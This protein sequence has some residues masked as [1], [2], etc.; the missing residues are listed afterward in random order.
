MVSIRPA[1]PSRRHRPPERELRV[2]LLC[3]NNRPSPRQ[4]SITCSCDTVTLYL[5]TPAY[6]VSIRLIK[7]MSHLS[8]AELQP[9]TV[10]LLIANFWT[11]NWSWSYFATARNL[12]N[13]CK[14]DNV[15]PATS[16]ARTHA[17][18]H[19]DRGLQNC[20]LYLLATQHLH[21]QTVYQYAPHL[22]A[23]QHLHSQTVYQ[24]APHLLATQHLHS[25]TISMPHKYLFHIFSKC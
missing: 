3:W 16:R 1:N 6:L 22:L 20:N 2:I 18:T 8:H 9:R 10:L 4:L 12:N 7:L 23:P 24:Y 15:T 21:S 13:E 5:H 25:Q 11:K 14:L 19:T 17:H